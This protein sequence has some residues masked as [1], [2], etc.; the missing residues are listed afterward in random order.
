MAGSLIGSVDHF[1]SEGVSESKINI[2]AALYY[3]FERMVS[4]GTATRIALQY[5]DGSSG[6]GYS[7]DITSFGTGAFAC[8]RMNRATT[9]GSPIYILIQVHTSTFG[10]DPGAPALIIGTTTSGNGIAAAVRT[11][12]ES[13]WNGTTANNGT[14]SKGDP[15]WV[16]GSNGNGLVFPCSNG[17]SG[18]HVT[19]KENM[20]AIPTNA[21]SSNI[22]YHILGDED[23]VALFYDTNDDGS[24][25]F[26]YVGQFFPISGSRHA[27]EADA[28]IAMSTNDAS[29]D[30]FT[31]YGTY[32]GTGNDQ[33]GVA[34][35][36]GTDSTHP[37]Q[38]AR[39]PSITEGKRGNIY[40]DGAGRVEPELNLAVVSNQLHVSGILGQIEF[41]RET[42]KN[43][44]GESVNS[45]STRAVFAGTST[46]TAK[47]TAPW[48]AINP[49]RSLNLSGGVQF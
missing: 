41:I 21:G 38:I 5:G 47:T 18:S 6:P 8:Y 49:P 28:L 29:I 36:P 13:P 19:S 20:M 25:G 7:G 35:G 37:F 12:G 24:Y 34:T 31:A 17:V 11:D 2:F 1:F 43:I 23:S 14:D 42:N 9:G 30:D 3:F 15:V 48:G 46:T 4:A 10:D 39:L 26:T 27:T 33:G 32:T 40:S 22:R 44:A 16:T 45:D